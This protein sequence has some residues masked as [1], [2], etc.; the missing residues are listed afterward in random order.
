M[1]PLLNNSQIPQNN[2]SFGQMSNN[3]VAFVK[4]QMA[5]GMNPEQLK[6]QIFERHPQLK[7]MIQ[8]KYGNMSY[9]DIAKQNGYDIQNDLSK[10]GL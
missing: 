3:I 4:E 2:M 1:N 9:Q 7:G 8:Q 5:R 6:Q 10:L